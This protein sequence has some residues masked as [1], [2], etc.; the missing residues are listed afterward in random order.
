MVIY[1]HSYNKIMTY[2]TS[3]QYCRLLVILAVA[4]AVVNLKNLLLK[5]K[6]SL[7]GDPNYRGLTL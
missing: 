5:L 4:V 1:V 6:G 2:N 7:V 3:C